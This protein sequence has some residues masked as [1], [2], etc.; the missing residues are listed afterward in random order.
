M[1]G[2]AS[3]A[4]LVWLLIILALCIAQVRSA[5]ELA[6]LRAILAQLTAERDELRRRM[7]TLQACHRNLQALYAQ[8]TQDLLRLSGY[9]LEIWIQRKERP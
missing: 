6:E 7:I 2:G 3:W 8:R 4:D 9:R 5:T 1:S